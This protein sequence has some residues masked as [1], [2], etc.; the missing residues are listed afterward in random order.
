MS[1]PI[2]YDEVAAALGLGP[3]ELIAIVGGGGKTSLL[4]AL[5]R[6][7][8]GSVVLTTTTKM[9]AHRTEGLAVLRSPSDAELADW[10]GLAERSAMGPAAADRDTVLAWSHDQGQKAIGVDPTICDHWFNLVDHVAVEADGARGRPAKAP[11]DHEPVIPLRATM[12]V[13]VIGADALD[14]VI[15]DQCH[16]PLRVAAVVGCRSYERLT[17]G[18]AAALLTSER[19]LR[20]GVPPSARFGV[21]ITKVDDD[22][23][24]LVAALTASL[25]APHP[26]RPD[27]VVAVASWGPDTT[28]RAGDTGDGPALGSLPG[29]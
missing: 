6:S 20:R 5:G 18:R 3:H 21:V 15:E 7:L 17:P 11:G 13:A 26:G 23:R 19:G 28:A 12:V 29:R 9:N 14:R 16:R 27:V 22:N 8:H 25:A 10:A 1:E 4:F 2:T 24:P